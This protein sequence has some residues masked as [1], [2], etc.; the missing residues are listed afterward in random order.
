MDDPIAA[1]E[2]EGGSAVRMAAGHMIGTP[3]QIAWAVQIK[4]QVDAEFDR[5][6]Q[7]LE[8]AATKQSPE[9]VTDI[10]AIVRILEDKRAE[11]MENELAGYFIHDWQD[12]RDQVSQMVIRDPRY[13]AIKASQI[14]RFGPGSARGP[15]PRATKP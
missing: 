9:N 5:V 3:N 10:S 8:H 15:N 2:S 4:S 11:V 1:W 7:V 6:R 14:A 13:E 12:L